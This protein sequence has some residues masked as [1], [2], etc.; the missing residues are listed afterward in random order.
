MGKK[1]PRAIPRG[2]QLTIRDEHHI[3]DR[4]IHFLEL[5]VV[6]QALRKTGVFRAQHHILL[7]LSDHENSSQ[8]DI[9]EEL[10][11]SPASVAAS[12]KKLVQGGYIEKKINE[13]DARYYEV[14]LT[15]LGRSIVTES[16][17]IFGEYIETMYAGI[18]D[19]EMQASI[20]TM[21]K[22]R[23]NL[24]AVLNKGKEE[25]SV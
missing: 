15:P 11:I 13:S 9:A 4:E 21:L 7:Y 6:E 14:T 18:P 20:Q 19:E 2:S 25:E 22:I 24:Q 8:K 17:R 1:V 16:Y 3:L 23:D 12:V 5:R 10:H